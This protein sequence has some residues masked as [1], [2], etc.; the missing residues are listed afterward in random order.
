MKSA[1]IKNPVICITCGEQSENHHGMEMLGDGL[2]KKGYNLQDM[3]EI[4]SKF[5]KLGGEVEWIHLD[6]YADD[7]EEASVVILRNGVNVL[8]RNSRFRKISKMKNRSDDEKEE[9]IERAKNTDYSEELFRQLMSFKWDQKYWDNRRGK[10]LNKRARWNVVFNDKGREPDY[11]NKKGTI[12]AYSKVPYLKAWKKE[13][14]ALCEENKPFQTE[15][16]LYYDSSKCGIGFHGDGE[17]K[18]IVAA[19]IGNGVIREIHWQWFQ[20]GKPIGKRIKVKLNNG[21]MY[22]MSEKASGF[23]WKKRNIKTLRHAAAVSGSKYL[24]I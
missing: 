14:E 10:V 15:G 4:S 1:L 7:T 23:D 13:I 24:E 21:D 3:M 17:R 6:N 19:N 2:A 9:L 8:L 20:K 22:I 18:K 11:E 16:N 12:I 5:E